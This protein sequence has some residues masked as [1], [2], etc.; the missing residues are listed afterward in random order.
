MKTMLA[1]LAVLTLG[2]CNN[3]SK[4]VS[5]A[6][7]DAQTPGTSSGAGATF[8][9][10]A[11]SAAPSTQVAQRRAAYYPQPSRE[12]FVYGKPAV[13]VIKSDEAQPVPVEVQQQQVPVPAWIDE[14]VETTYG[15]HQDAAGIMKVA[16]SL[17]AWS[18]IRWIGICFVL[19]SLF[20]LAW[21]HNNPEGY[22]LVC[23]KFLAG[24]LFLAII[25]PNPWWGLV[26]L[27][28]AG[29]YAW[30]KSGLKIGI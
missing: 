7:L 5:R 8:V 3:S 18:K 29:F 6:V 23:W 16:L 28:P 30:Q 2:G 20:G 26:L 21:S 14:R 9:G 17:A 19:F 1:I 10:P 12:S 25:D 13:P 24:G 22:P 11:N 27:I 15:Q 4:G